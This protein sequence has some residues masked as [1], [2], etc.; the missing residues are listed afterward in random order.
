MAAPVQAA[1]LDEKVYENITLPNLENVKVY[2]E[3][4]EKFKLLY[5]NNKNLS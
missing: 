2:D 4:F 1:S 3:V 5:Q